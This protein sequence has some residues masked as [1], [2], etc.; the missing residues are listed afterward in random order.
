MIWHQRVDAEDPAC[1]A[2]CL[3]NSRV[4]ADAGIF[5][6][7]ARQY[8]ANDPLMLKSRFSGSSP[9]ACS[10]AIFV[11]VPQGQRSIMPAQVER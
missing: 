7:T 4:V 8:R 9:L 1:V 10:T 11:P 6:Q 5:Y 3:H 2:D